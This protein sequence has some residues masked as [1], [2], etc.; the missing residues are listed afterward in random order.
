M[1]VTAYRGVSYY[2]HPKLEII[3]PDNAGVPF[4]IQSSTNLKDWGTIYTTD[5]P[6]AKS[7]MLH[8]DQASPMN[9]F[10][11]RLLEEPSTP[12]NALSASP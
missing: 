5:F 2:G 10:R 12:A 3:E 7:Y 8:G 1:R 4:D 9:F 11:A 6:W